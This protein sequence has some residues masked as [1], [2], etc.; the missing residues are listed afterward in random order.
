MKFQ[1]LQPLCEGLQV[2]GCE[3]GERSYEI[4]FDKDYPEIGYA[5]GWGPIGD[6][7]NFLPDQ[8]KSF[9]AAKKALADVQRQKAN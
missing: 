4:S 8:Y 3:D 7:I 2:W 6:G 9:R 5:A 1:P